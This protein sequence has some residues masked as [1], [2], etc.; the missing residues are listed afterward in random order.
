MLARLTL[1]FCNREGASEFQKIWLERILAEAYRRRAWEKRNRRL[2]LT[3][4]SAIL[5][6]AVLLPALVT[7]SAEIR[8]VRYASIIVSLLVAIATIADR[9]LRP[10]PR[11]RLY[12][13]GADMLSGEAFRFFSELD[14]YKGLAPSDRF[15]LFLG[16]FEELAIDFHNRYREDIDETLPKEKKPDSDEESTA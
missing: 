11:W 9:I 13:W 16:R 8:W 7:A 5:S 4:Q 10:G 2:F 1:E 3:T 12:R 15:S 6:G 14:P